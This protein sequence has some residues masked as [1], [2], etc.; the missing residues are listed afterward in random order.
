M[1]D[2]IRN[3]YQGSTFKVFIWKEPGISVSWK[4]HTMQFTDMESVR[5][6]HEVTR[7]LIEH[8][9]EIENVDSQKSI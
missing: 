4:N 1:T 6:W 8:S 3:I 9:K 2:I 5:E 7:I